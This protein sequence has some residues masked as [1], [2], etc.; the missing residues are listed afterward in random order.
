[1][2]TMIAYRQNKN[3]LQ[4]KIQYEKR[5]KCE[6]SYIIFVCNSIM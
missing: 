3:K 1:M 6:P 5:L 4:L 2:Y